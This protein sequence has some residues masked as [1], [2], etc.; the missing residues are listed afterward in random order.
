MESYRVTKD[1]P[2][3]LF[4]A[5]DY[6]RT[7]AFVFGQN[8]PLE[9]EFGHDDPD[10][11]L[12]AIVLIEDHKPVAGCRITYPQDGIGKIGRVCVARERQRTG[13]GHVLIEQAEQWIAEKG[14]RHIVINSQD[15]AAAFYE[16]CGY[17]LVP[18]VDPEIYETH[19]PSPQELEAHQQQRGSLGFSC[20][21]VEKYL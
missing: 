5:Y 6:V 9:M 20:V 11:E 17:R 3:W 13:V 8:I 19:R 18:G 12:E 14:V 16:K 7:D 21:L 2:N 4:K 15:R 1:A 10:E